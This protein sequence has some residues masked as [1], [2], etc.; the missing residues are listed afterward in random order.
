MTYADAYAEEQAMRHEME[1]EETSA[2]ISINHR[3]K[4]DYK[5]TEN[6][7]LFEFEYFPNGKILPNVSAKY[8]ILHTASELLS[9]KSSPPNRNNQMLIKEPVRSIQLKSKKAEIDP[10][11]VQLS[12]PSGNPTIQQNPKK[13]TKKNQ[14]DAT[15]S[16]PNDKCE[17]KVSKTEKESNFASKEKS[18]TRQ[19]FEEMYQLRQEWS[20]ERRLWREQFDRVSANTERVITSESP[21]FDRSFS[22]G[23]ISDCESK[24]RS[25]TEVALKNK[26]DSRESDFEILLQ[27]VRG[28]IQWKVSAQQAFR[29]LMIPKREDSAPKE[30]IET[31]E[32]HWLDFPTLKGLSSEQMKLVEATDGSHLISHLAQRLEESC[33]EKRKLQDAYDALERKLVAESNSQ[34]ERTHEIIPPI[35]VCQSTNT[36]G[37]PKKC[38]NTIPKK[39]PNT[40]VARR[41]PQDES[42]RQ[43]WLC[44]QCKHRKNQRQVGTKPCVRKTSLKGR[45]QPWIA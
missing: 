18:E 15:L 22:V 5:S 28:A 8:Q 3:Q 42:P 31:L 26:H 7:P 41:P 16:I 34:K 45:T 36:N 32:K 37:S 20:E 35:L 17:E 33:A 4:S 1:E 40:K 19:L 10:I 23:S 27:F 11:L 44:T 12:S 13:S 24:N 9:K 29:A 25:L 14:I 30:F 6:S 43:A 39:C 2:S 21:S 38:T